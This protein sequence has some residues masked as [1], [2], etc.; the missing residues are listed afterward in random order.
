MSGGF[1]E[2]SIQDV[3]RLDDVE[4]RDLIRR[5]CDAE[6]RGQQLPL[7]CLVAGGHQNA[8]GSMS[9]YAACQRP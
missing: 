6:V 7:V 3:Q 9:V 2:V 5:L 4:A 8:A 1:L